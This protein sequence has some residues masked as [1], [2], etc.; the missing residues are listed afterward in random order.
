MK[1]WFAKLPI[2]SKLTALTAGSTTVV[3]AIAAGVLGAYQTGVLRRALMQ[4]VTTEANIVGRNSTAALAFGDRQ[5][6]READQGKDAEKKDEPKQEVKPKV[7]PK[8]P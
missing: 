5:A 7:Q 8:K 4:K 6:A 1:T 2:R 3:L